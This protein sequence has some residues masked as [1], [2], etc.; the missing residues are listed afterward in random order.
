[1]GV[2]PDRRERA[3]SQPLLEGFRMITKSVAVVLLGAGL[4]GAP[5]ASAAAARSTPA[6]AARLTPA[7]RPWTVASGL[8]NPRGLAFG[9]HGELFFA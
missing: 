6:A 3:G 1:M 5:S 9:S 7:A 8:N 4:L 2:R